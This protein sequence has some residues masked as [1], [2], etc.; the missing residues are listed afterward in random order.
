M[1]TK[2]L[3]STIQFSNNNQENTPRVFSQT[4]NSVHDDNQNRV[5]FPLIL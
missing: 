2:M 5:A 3:A 4:P 1:A